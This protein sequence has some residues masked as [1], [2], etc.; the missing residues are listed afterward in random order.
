MAPQIKPKPPQLKSKTKAPVSKRC[1]LWD[2][3]NTRDRPA[4]I[5]QL[6]GTPQ[7]C[8]TDTRNDTAASSDANTA[9]PFCSVHNWNAWSP[10]ELAGRLP[11]RPMIRTLAQ[12][13]GN[14]WEM[15][16]NS[17]AEVVH[18][19]NE[20]ERAGV[21]TKDAARWWAEKVI[22]EL[23]EG[24]GMRIVGPSCASDEGGSKWLAEF[25]G[26][27]GGE[28]DGCRRLGMR[29]ED[30]GGKGFGKGKGDADKDGDG[31]GDV[32]GEGRGGWPDYLGLH[33]YGTEARDAMQYIS[34]MHKKYG[35][36]VMVSEIASVSRDPKQ[37]ERFTDE[38]SEWMDDT[39]WIV[40]Y[41]FFGCMAHVADDFVSPAAQLMDE[42][43]KF[44]PLMGRLM[45]L[46]SGEGLK[47]RK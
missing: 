44:T 16:L 9:S 8:N 1:L 5:N 3:T 13:E 24:K 25:M 41:G 40:E 7:T 15:V 38:M 37:V 46:K 19:L 42:G 10:P 14:E 26:L 39:H 43:G 45:G 12:L 30:G 22:P 32:D 17:G 21:S 36:P 31:D 4:A 23:R 20:P 47:G 27:V 2:W 29:D 18:F 11:F 34:T 33:Y 6:F 28:D 35:L